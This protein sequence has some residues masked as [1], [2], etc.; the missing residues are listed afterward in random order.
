MMLSLLIL[1]GC[2][3]T[4]REVFQRCIASGRSPRY[5]EWRRQD[6]EKRASKPDPYCTTNV[7]GHKVYT[8]CW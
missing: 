1:G 7:Y 8:S 2:L 6:F 5:C 3:T 4:G